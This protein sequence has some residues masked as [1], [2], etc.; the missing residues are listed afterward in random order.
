MR[1]RVT[2]VAVIAA[3]VAMTLFAVP[4]AV[5]SRSL[6]LER[7]LAA[8]EVAALSATRAVT[9]NAQ[10]PIELPATDASTSLT[11]YDAA[12]RR[13]A[14]PGPADA[15]SA[16]RAALRDN[17]TR[18]VQGD[19]LVA[20]VPVTRDEAVVAVVEAS[21][22][23]A[24]LWRQV[25]IAWGLLLAGALIAISA[26]IAVAR[27]QSRF[28][29]LPLEELTATA[30]RTGEGDLS[31]R[32]GRSGITELDELAAA[33][34]TML[35]A[36][37]SALERERRFS[38]DASH[39]LRTPLA[40]ILLRLE[41]A[42]AAP[43]TVTS[44]WIHQAQAE[45][46][47]L[48]ETVTD[49]LQAVRAGVTEAPMPIHYEPLID[50]L[51]AAESRWRSVL[52]EQGRRLEIVIEADVSDGMVSARVVGHIVDVLIE[53]AVEHGLGRVRLTAR[54]TAGAVA[55]DVADEGTLEASLDDPFTRG[56][57]TGEGPG[58]GLSLARTMAAVAGA[59]LLL[60]DRAPTRFT[61]FLPPPAE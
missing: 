45:V 12:A 59:R 38:A 31:A 26:G 33:H 37:T 21:E 20:A 15:D 3:I 61:L 28:L 30:V 51:T 48:Q 16:V 32:A 46:A 8:L 53:N 56:L 6:L 27:R 29:V 7:E 47:R 55:I 1:R 36:L 4:L 42:Q 52:A 58:V 40:R 35:D 9:V 13:I 22:P 14:G 41:T 39:Q 2:R 25:A 19:R 54:A 49:I 11:V 18:G 44:D 17:P 50:I 10:D 24:L 5:V 23:T 34:N 57:S 43:G 60:T